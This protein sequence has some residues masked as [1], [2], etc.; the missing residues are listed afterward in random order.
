MQLLCDAHTGA[1]ELPHVVGVLSIGILVAQDEIDGPHL[2]VTLNQP[3]SGGV[4]DQVR[5]RVCESVEP[6]ASCHHQGCMQGD[7]AAHDINVTNLRA[8][9]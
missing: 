9:T 6:L 4:L 3:V 8:R 5:C 7:R 2:H 1:V